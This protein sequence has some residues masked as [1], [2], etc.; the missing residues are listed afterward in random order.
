MSLAQKSK[1]STQ[2]FLRTGAAF[3]K[4][5]FS[6]YLAQIGKNPAWKQLNECKNKILPA[7]ECFDELA[8]GHYY[9]SCLI[10][11]GIIAKQ[12]VKYDCATKICKKSNKRAKEKSFCTN[13]CLFS[14]KNQP[15]NNCE[16]SSKPQ[17]SSFII[18]SKTLTAAVPQ[19]WS[20][21]WY[22]VEGPLS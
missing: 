4:E 20:N 21:D 10:T 8:V 1:G 3:I 15:K 7:L 11:T 16:K 9:H 22:T 6:L 17:M 14:V 12:T 2:Q 19:S 13:S 5:K 18:V